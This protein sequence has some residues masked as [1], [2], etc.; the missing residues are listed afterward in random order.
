MNVRFIFNQL[1]VLQQYKV[2]GEKTAN[3]PA[4]VAHLYF[5]RKKDKLPLLLRGKEPPAER[6]LTGSIALLDEV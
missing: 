3:S 2:N 4:T 6:A 1:R 5:R